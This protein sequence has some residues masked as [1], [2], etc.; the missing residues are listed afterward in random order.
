MANPKKIVQPLD[1]PVRKSHSQVV[2]VTGGTLVFIAGMTSRSGEDATPVHPGDMRAQLRQ[3]CENI[4]RALRSVGGDY[5]DVVKTTTFTTDVDE[6]H[7]VN[8]ERHKYFKTDLPTSALI[9]VKRLAGP[10]LMIEIE[11]MAVIRNG[12]KQP[13]K[14]VDLERSFVADCCRAKWSV[15]RNTTVNQRLARLIRK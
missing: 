2:A 14:T 12:S 8:D 6:Y 3:V 15:K 11:C 13:A 7:S 10:A 4:G 9:G 5:S 1:L